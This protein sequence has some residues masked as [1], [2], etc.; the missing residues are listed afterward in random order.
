MPDMGYR[1]RHIAGKRVVWRRVI[2]HPHVGG[3]FEGIA[4]EK[5]EDAGNKCA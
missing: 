4:D 1:N 5:E 3:D 2:D